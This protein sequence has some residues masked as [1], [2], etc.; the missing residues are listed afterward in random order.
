MPAPLIAVF[1]EITLGEAKPKEK[2]LWIAYAFCARFL[3]ADA[4]PVLSPNQR[5]SASSVKA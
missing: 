3:T 4:L 1:A 2:P 5:H